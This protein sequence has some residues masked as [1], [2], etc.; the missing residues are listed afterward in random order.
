MSLAQIGPL[1]AVLEDAATAVAAGAVIGSSAG[2]IAGLITRWPLEV[3]ERR[4]M[5]DGY[6]GA[7]IGALVAMVD[8]FLVYLL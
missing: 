3:L 7:A 6:K 4:A 8:T 2:G 1:T 5:G